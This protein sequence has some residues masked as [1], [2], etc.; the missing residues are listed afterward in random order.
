MRE[1]QFID[2]VMPDVPAASPAQLAA[3][4]ARVF[5]AAHETNA[6]TVERARRAGGLRRQALVDMVDMVDVVDMA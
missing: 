1:F 6:A 2:E 3:A 4:R 5:G